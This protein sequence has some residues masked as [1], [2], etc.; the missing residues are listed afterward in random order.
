MKQASVEIDSIRGT[1]KR[2]RVSRIVGLG[3]HHLRG[4]SMF[5]LSCGW[6]STPYFPTWKV[7]KA[8]VTQSRASTV[9]PGYQD[10]LLGKSSAKPS[11]VFCMMSAKLAS[12]ADMRRDFHRYDLHSRSAVPWSEV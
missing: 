6:W 9:L 2:K 1:L 10:G 4:V 8:I 12:G 5:R 11:E 3:C 7:S